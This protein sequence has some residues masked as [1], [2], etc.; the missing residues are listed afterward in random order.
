MIRFQWNALRVGDHV[1]VH[2]DGGVLQDGAVAF[3][4]VLEGSNGVGI[5][6]AGAGGNAVRWP[7]RLAVHNPKGD[8]DDPCAR[9]DAPTSGRLA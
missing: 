8:V 1:R 3:I 5:R 2:G 6:V 4:D 9:C 7:N